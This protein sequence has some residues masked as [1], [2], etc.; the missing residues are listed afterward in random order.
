MVTGRLTIPATTPP[1]THYIFLIGV[2]QNGSPWV[3]EN[4]ITVTRGSTP[5][6][7]DGTLS[8]TFD[9]VLTV[10]AGV[11]CTLEKATVNGAVQIGKGGLFEAD[12]STINGGISAVSSARTGDGGTD[13]RRGDGGPNVRGVEGLLRVR[14]TEFDRSDSP[15]SPPAP[16]RH[17]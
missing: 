1:G 6:A 11:A 5:P 9:G 4:S 12:N 3:L 2:A 16:Y 13:L 8:G 17:V 14:L 7:C 10:P 15:A